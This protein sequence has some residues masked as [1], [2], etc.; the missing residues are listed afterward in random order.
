MT[1]PTLILFIQ[2]IAQDRA[3]GILIAQDRAWGILI[4]LSEYKSI[5]T[6]WTV[7]NVNC[8]NVI[9][10]GIECVPKGF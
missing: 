9:S 7:L 10:F 1:N 4:N 3:W 5:Q 8:N 6:Y 2:E